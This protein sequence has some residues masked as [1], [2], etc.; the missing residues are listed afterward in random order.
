MRHAL[1]PTGDASEV[2]DIQHGI[3]KRTNVD[4]VGCVQAACGH[5][6]RHAAAH[7]HWLWTRRNGDRKDTT[8][9]RRILL[10]CSMPG[11]S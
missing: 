4:A 1:Q 7:C 6:A 9:R 11:V 2:H 5:L 3:D 8:Y 10:G